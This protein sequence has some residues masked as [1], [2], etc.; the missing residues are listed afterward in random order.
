M[1]QQQGMQDN[2]GIAQ[3]DVESEHS[4]CSLDSD[5]SI[6]EALNEM[7]NVGPDDQPKA[8]S[9]LSECKRC[10]APQGLFMS[11]FSHGAVMRSTKYQ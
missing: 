6:L 11:A 7:F 4:P 9:A 2:E 10:E 5:N 1:V 8:L 3:V